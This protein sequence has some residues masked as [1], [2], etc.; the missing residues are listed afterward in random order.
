MGYPKSCWVW[1]GHSQLSLGM[2]IPHKLDIGPYECQILARMAVDA[3]KVDTLL[4]CPLHG[5]A[6][7][8]IQWMHG[9]VRSC[10]IVP[11]NT[12]YEI[13]L[14]TFQWYTYIYC[15][16]DP[17]GNVNCNYTYNM[18]EIFEVLSMV[19]I[20]TMYEISLRSCQL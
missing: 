11:I 12:M 16:G 1:T 2:W 4:V 14:R 9:S 6:W 19:S 18:W 20:H 5:W 15:M 13:S 10:S 7:M 17:G 3:P 8:S